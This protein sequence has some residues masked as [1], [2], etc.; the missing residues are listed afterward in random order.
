[1][2]LRGM[3]RRYR[4]WKAIVLSALLFSLYH[5]AF[6][7]LVPTFVLGVAFGWIAVRTGS[8]WLL[9]LGHAL[10]NAFVWAVGSGTAGT[11]PPP[12]WSPGMGWYVTAIFVAIA[13]TSGGAALM[14]RATPSH[15]Q[16]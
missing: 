2:I 11:L 14:I 15:G 13:L 9:V 12:D 4:P 1:L 5:L 16:A 8:L 6:R 10:Y 7:Q 3:L